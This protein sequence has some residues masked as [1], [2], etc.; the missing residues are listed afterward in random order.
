LP[1]AGPNPSGCLDQC[2]TLTT[3]TNIRR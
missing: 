1:E 3:A 2:Q